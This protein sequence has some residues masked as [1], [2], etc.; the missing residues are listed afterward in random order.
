MWN[1][2]SCMLIVQIR[3]LLANI[4]EHCNHYVWVKDCNLICTKKLV[5]LTRRKIFKINEFRGFLVGGVQNPSVNGRNILLTFH[6]SKFYQLTVRNPYPA[7]WKCKY[8]G[9]SIFMNIFTTRYELKVG[10]SNVLWK[11]VSNTEEFRQLTALNPLSYYLRMQI[12]CIF[13]KLYEHL[14]HYVWV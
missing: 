4:Y 2:L 12:R 9:F 10:I 11:L 13:N 5:L 6:G 1:L 7:F 14:Y 8:D 3:C